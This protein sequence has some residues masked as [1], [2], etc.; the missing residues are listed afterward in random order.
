MSVHNAAER[1]E[2]PPQTG[3]HL[4]VVKKPPV[5]VPFE[6][7]SLTESAI[8]RHIVE[9]VADIKAGPKKPDPETD[10]VKDAKT[11]GSEGSK[12][13]KIDRDT[14]LSNKR[15]EVAIQVFQKFHMLDAV[16][17]TDFTE[18]YG[19]AEQVAINPDTDTRRELVSKVGSF[20]EHPV[21][22]ATLALSHESGVYT[23]GLE[24]GVIV[25]RTAAIL[26]EGV[27]PAGIWE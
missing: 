12:P 1:E 21:I 23:E 24:D 22:R 17:V 10:D 19:K 5:L 8:V 6:R 9:I 27:E 16:A 4:S 2:M 13:P 3:S 14:E 26:L 18:L 20:I 15:R 25:Q 11:N 7:D